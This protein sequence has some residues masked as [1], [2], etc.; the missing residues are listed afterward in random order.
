MGWL[1]RD[2]DCI[3]LVVV[4]ALLLQAAISSFAAGAMA[5]PLATGDAVV[6]CTTQGSVAKRELP[7]Q[8]HRKADHQCCTLA[9]RTAC[10]ASTGGIIPLA[11]RVPLPAA[12]E[13]PAKPPRLVQPYRRPAEG[14]PA[15]PRAPP[16]A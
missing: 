13:A 6:L 7:G 8:S 9:C 16:Q 12:V 1:R 15:Q 2:K 11:V 14:S 10:G 4:W 5:A 3:A